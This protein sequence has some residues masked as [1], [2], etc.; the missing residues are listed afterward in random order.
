MFDSLAEFPG[1]TPW[2]T[3]DMARVHVQVER[4]HVEKLTRPSR[5]FA[6]IAELIW[7]GLDAEATNVKVSL[8]ENGLGGVDRVVVTDNGHG[9][10]NEEAHRHFSTLGG[11]WKRTAPGRHSRTKKRVLHGSEGQGRWR[12]FGV[13]T[14]VTWTTVAENAGR[15]ER[16][17]IRGSL[18]DLTDFDISDPEPTDDAPGTRVDIENIRPESQGLLGERVLEAL[19]AEFALYLEKYDVTVV[20]RG[21]R[22]DPAAVQ[23]RR[24]DLSVDLPNPHGEVAVTVIEWKREFPRSMLLCDEEGVVLAEIPPGVQ[25][26]GLDFTIYVK[27]AGFRTFENELM[28]ADL[29]NPNISPTI[30]AVRD[31]LRQ[32]FKS[33]LKEKTAELIEEWKREQVYPYQGDATSPVDKVERE[34]FNVVAVAAAPAVNSSGDRPGR[35]LSLR[36]LKEAMEA[37]PGSL[38]RVLQEVLDLP[39]ERLDE[40]THLLDR[41][42]LSNIVAAAH[43]VTNRLDFLSGLEVLLFES[44]NKKALLERRQLH[45]I[46]A[47]ETWVFGDEYVLAVDDEPLT[48]VLTKHLDLLGRTELAPEVEERVLTEEG[49]HGV[50]DLMLS[51][52]V[53]L[54]RNREHLVIEL[55]RPSVKIGPD[56]I[57]Q[58]EKYAFAVAGDERFANTA[59]RWDFWVISNEMTEYATR[60]S[61][62]QGLPVGAV[63]QEDNITIWVRTWGQIIEDCRRRLKFV[64]D[65]LNY[66]STRDNA[67]DYLRS[68][69]AR[70]LPEKVTEGAAPEG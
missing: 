9:M 51:K 2:Q 66:R 29:G 12:A 14:F 52:A 62:Q 31:A 15:R 18:D 61:H 58:I 26:P 64:Q 57:T 68:A 28:L 49:V 37:N 43:V 23:E 46:L 42:S 27:W 6:G 34:L 8:G 32:H 60:R 7:N 65:N 59:T 40:L 35:R 11:S 50:V 70:Y 4:D 44:D 17:S 3:L 63:H 69:H 5:R 55:K 22:L 19:T 25:A 39:K 56:Q 36:L 10:T 24:D 53:E 48:Q 1:G 38:H 16:T 13:G 45:R 41:T 20:Y 54:P 33:R 21:T 30:D 67:I 47:A